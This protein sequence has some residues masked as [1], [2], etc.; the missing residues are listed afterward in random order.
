MNNIIELVKVHKKY[1]D[2]KNNEVHALRGVNLEIKSGESV[3]IMGV[4][5]SGKST[6]LNM[7]G[8]IDVSTSGQFV[9]EDID[10]SSKSQTE[11]AKVRNNTFGFVLQSYGLIDSDTVAKNVNLPLLFSDKYT[12]KESKQ[13]TSKTLK[14]LNIDELQKQ[15]VRELS[16]GQK[17]RVAIARAIVNDPKIILADEPTSALDSKTANEIIAIFKDLQKQGK[18]IIVVTHDKAVAD[19]MDRTVYIKDGVISE[20]L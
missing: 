10:I 5:G 8:C 4:S 1:N 13:I 14:L 18:T 3:A 12:I 19:Q 20:C 6:L 11:L 15:K 7:I 2:G 17:Q 9:L 16:G